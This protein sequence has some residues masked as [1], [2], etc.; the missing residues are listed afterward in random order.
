MLSKKGLKLASK[1]RWVFKTPPVTYRVKLTQ[2]IQSRP[3]VKPKICRPKFKLALVCFIKFP[4]IHHH[5][6][7]TNLLEFYF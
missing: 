3:F 5:Q 2:A 6:T 7:E 4:D 1:L